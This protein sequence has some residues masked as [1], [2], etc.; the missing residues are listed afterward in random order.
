VTTLALPL[1]IPWV[2]G[3]L[4]IV[5][6]GRRR[7]VG[8]LAAAALA[9]HLAALGVLAARVLGAGSQQMATGGWPADVGIVLRADSLGIVF[10]LISAIA[11]LAAM[12]H[13]VLEGVE[14]RTF[15]GLVVLLATGLTG[16][17]LT[18]D[19][20]N[21]YV[22]FEI[23]MTAAYVLTTY[24]G[25][26]RAMGAALVF[27]AVNPFQEFA[28][29]HD[30]PGMVLPHHAEALRQPRQLVDVER[31]ELARL[32]EKI[33]AVDR[34]V[35]FLP[36]QFEQGLDEFDGFGCAKRIEGRN[37]RRV[38]VPGNVAGRDEVWIEQLGARED[39]RV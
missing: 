2:A 37:F 30:S 19:I 9:A 24:G 17:F 23:A 16:L 31:L 33:F 3:T 28:R 4:L 13:A 27:A 8:W 26:R 35:G 15:A 1:L 22:F 38:D 12:I 20:F 39:A 18:G 14:E 5:L 34:A 32:R 21:F 6:D 36:R 29:A 25:G 10:A 7:L 11:L